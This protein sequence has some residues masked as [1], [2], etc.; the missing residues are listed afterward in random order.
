RAL[1][2]PGRGDAFPPRGRRRGD[3]RDR[4]VRPAAPVPARSG[5][6]AMN[7]TPSSWRDRPAAQMPAYPDASALAAAESCLAAA[8]PPATIAECRVLAAR[9]A[10]AAEGRAFLLQG[11]DC[12]ES[13]AEFGADKVRTT[14]N[15]LLDMAAT[16]AAAGAR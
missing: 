5:G 2:D 4:D 8:A 13:F 1:P 15:L 6:G 16:V 10:A 14:F 11:G 12:A 9:I 7:W 3:P